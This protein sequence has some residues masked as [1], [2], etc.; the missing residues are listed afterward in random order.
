MSLHTLFSFL[1]IRMVTLFCSPFRFNHVFPDSTRER[2]W[3]LCGVGSEPVCL[4]PPLRCPSRGALR[5]FLTCSHYRRKSCS[6]DR[7]RTPVPHPDLTFLEHPWPW[8]ARGGRAWGPRC[9]E[10][11][12]SEPDGRGPCVRSG[13]LRVGSEGGAPGA[14]ARVASSARALE[15]AS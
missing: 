11:S 9:V 14:A 3:P 6:S 13:V 7:R 10:V 4:R 5:V 8:G 1:S 2:L 15:R 12:C